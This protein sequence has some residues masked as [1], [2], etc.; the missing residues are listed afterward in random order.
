MQVKVNGDTLS[1]RNEQFQ[2]FLD[3]R[4]IGYEINHKNAIYCIERFGI[5]EILRAEFVNVY[6][7]LV[8][9]KKYE[10]MGYTVYYVTFPAR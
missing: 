1:M 4:R 9:A 7:L 5:A 2:A 10:K 6:P 3:Q 8:V